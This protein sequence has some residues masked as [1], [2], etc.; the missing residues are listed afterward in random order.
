MLPL[1]P[2][3]QALVIKGSQAGKQEVTC[4]KHVGIPDKQKYR[5]AADYDCWEVDPPLPWKRT[6]DPNTVIMLNIC[7]TDYLMRI[8]GHQTDAH[9][10]ILKVLE[11]ST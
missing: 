10:Q 6:L 11:K 7:P 4:I 1:K 9:D 3:C 5:F 2:G 8:D